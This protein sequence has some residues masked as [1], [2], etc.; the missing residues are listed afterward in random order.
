MWCTRYG[1]AALLLVATTSAFA[2]SIAAKV[3]NVADGDTITVQFEDKR[4]IRVR[5]Q[6]IDAPE[7]GQ[8]YS[9]V[10]RR[11]LHERTMGKF[12][13]CDF[14]MIDRHGRAVAVVRVDGNEIC[15]VPLQSGLAWHFKRYQL[16]QTADDRA[17]Y[18]AA[19]VVAIG[20]TAAAV[21]RRELSTR[22]RANEPLHRPVLTAA[23][24]R[25]CVV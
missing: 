10:S 9:Q 8:R 7:R 20:N 21:Y 23:V 2:A 19:E 5:L 11:N 4:R 1:L 13:T 22:H 24:R 25:L 6:G 15:L 3:I 18:A 16:E 12:V 17:A 14:E